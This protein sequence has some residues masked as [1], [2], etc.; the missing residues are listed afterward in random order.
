VAARL[1]P[2]TVLPLVNAAMAHARLGETGPAAAKL[3]RALSLQPDD[4]AAN[5]NLGLLLAEQGMAPEAEAALR[6]ALESDPDLAGA[7]FNLGVLLAKDRLPEAL[8]FLRRACALR[9]GNGKYVYTLAFYL[10]RS[11]GATEAC[12]LLQEAVERNRANADIYLLLGE[13]YLKQGRDR[14][15]RRAFERARVLQGR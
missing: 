9:P 2:D 10:D 15:A 7:A 4:A 3:Q 6:K 1:R 12:R 13:I 8:R 5:F 14:A 11:G